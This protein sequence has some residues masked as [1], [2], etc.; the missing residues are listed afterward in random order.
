MVACNEK[1][2]AKITIE[3]IVIQS[4]DAP[5]VTR[6]AVQVTPFCSALLQAQEAAKQLNIST[7]SLVVTRFGKKLKT[8]DTLAPNDQIAW[9]SPAALDVNQARQLRVSRQRK[10]ARAKRQGRTSGAMNQDTE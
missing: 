2:S 1:A 5:N 6:H 10:V 4:G 3:A 8:S 9:L 7:H